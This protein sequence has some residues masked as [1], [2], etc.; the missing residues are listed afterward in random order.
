MGSPAMRTRAPMIHAAAA[1]NHC[2]HGERPSSSLVATWTGAQ[3]RKS[4][5]SAAMRRAARTFT[6]AIAV[7]PDAVELHA[8][9]DEPEPELLRDS[10][11]Q[12]FEFVVDEL[13]HVSSLDVD[14]MVVVGLRRG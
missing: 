11:L 13:D 14:Q 1:R 10:F 5:S 4:R 9:V 12:R 3:N 6:L 2:G 7:G 8:M